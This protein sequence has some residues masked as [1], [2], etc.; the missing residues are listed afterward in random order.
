METNGPKSETSYTWRNEGASLGGSDEN[1]SGGAGQFS[2]TTGNESLRVGGTNRTRCN[3]AQAASVSGGILLQLIK[4]AEDQLE[5][6][7]ECIKWY[8]AQKTKIQNYLEG[9]KNLQE[10]EDQGHQPEVTNENE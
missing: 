1:S 2:R 8:E 3:S 4:Q 7:D 5:E 9:L 6:T 10:L